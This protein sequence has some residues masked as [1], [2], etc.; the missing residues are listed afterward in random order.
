MSIY[1]FRSLA[2]EP[3]GRSEALEAT[4]A[5]AGE[6]IVNNILA[7]VPTEA[8]TFVAST[9]PLVVINGK[10]DAVNAWVVFALAALIT[11]LVRWL[12]KATRWVWITTIV[13]FF[14]WMSLVPSGALYLAC[15]FI[16]DIQ[17]PLMLLAAGFSA[18]ITILASA[19]KIK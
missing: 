4:P 5:N 14:L 17:I 10:P 1:Q 12:G 18:I 13:A 19:G 2:P 11:W 8:V 9:T 6:T 16:R 15:S 3:A 7:H